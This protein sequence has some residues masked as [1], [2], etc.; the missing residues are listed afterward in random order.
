MEK[1]TLDL[2]ESGDYSDF[3]LRYGDNTYH[4]HRNIVCPKSDILARALNGDFKVSSVFQLMN[5]VAAD[6]Y[7]RRARQERLS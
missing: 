4:L 7:P 1:Y 5:R 6:W 3:K 2:L